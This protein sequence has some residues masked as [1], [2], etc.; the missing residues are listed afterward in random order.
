MRLYFIT[1]SHLIDNFSKRILFVKHAV[2]AN[3]KTMNVV[4]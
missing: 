3:A 2:N 4:T 1:K